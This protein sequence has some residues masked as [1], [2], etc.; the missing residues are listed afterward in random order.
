MRTY[1]FLG[2]FILSFVF[3]YSQND[4]KV[5]VFTK[6]GEG[7]VHDNIAASIDAIKQLGEE[8][9]FE[10]D[11]SDNPNMFRE[12]NLNQYDALVFSN[13]NNKVFDNDKQKLAFIRYIEA[14][15]GFVGIHSACAT[16][17]DWPWFW[18]VVGGKFVRHAPF[19]EFSIKII[20][21]THLST[22]FFETD[23]TR[24]DECYYVNEIN[25]DIHVLLAADLTT[26]EDEGKGEYPGNTFGDTFPL[27]WCHEFDGGRQWFTALGH[28]IEDY[29]DPVFLKHLLGGIQW[30]TENGKPD[31]SKAKSTSI[32]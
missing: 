5:L 8:N 23:W 27:A 26:V 21:P 25:P 24:E 4:K 17:R 6:N 11:V 10:V 16:E 18:K 3:C 30:A 12:D 22:A 13:T 9:N 14:G 1:F 32:K 7:Y 15:G 29:S 19:Q 20:D 28:S 31:F 2:L